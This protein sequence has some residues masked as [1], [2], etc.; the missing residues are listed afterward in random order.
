[1]NSS[2]MIDESEKSKV[3]KEQQTEEEKLEKKEEVRT[4][5]PFIPSKNAK[6]R[7]G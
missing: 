7:D 2:E 1:M 4:Y 5:H 3:Q 6:V